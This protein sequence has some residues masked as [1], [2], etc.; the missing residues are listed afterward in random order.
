MMNNRRRGW[1]PSLFHP[2]QT[3]D[4]WLCRVKPFLSTLTSRQA[5]FIAKA[6]SDLGNG[7]MNLSQKANLQL[8]GFTPDHIQH[9]IPL[10]QREKLCSPNVI[11]EEKRN[12]L[13]SPLA[14]IDPSC[15]PDTLNYAHCLQHEIIEHDTIKF[16]TGK[17]SFVIDGGGQFPLTHH[18]ADLNLRVH[19]NQWMLQMGQ[20]KQAIPCSLDNISELIKKILQFCHQHHYNRLLHQDHTEQFIKETA[21]SQQPYMDSIHPEKLAIGLFTHGYHLGIPFGLLSSQAL[22]TLADLSDRYGDSTLRLTPDRTIILPYCSANAHPYLKSF[23]TDQDDP[24]LQII[25]C[26]GKPYC[27]QGQQPVMNDVRKLI[28]FWHKRQ[29]TLH[30]SGCAKGCASPQKNPVTL[31]A[32]PKGYNLILDGKADDK[33]LY[34]DLSL[35]EI[36]TQLITYPEIY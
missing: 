5:R 12:L 35:T 16:L 13:V 9:F 26:P 3:G 24:R 29:Q 14:G 11:E 36:T 17:F 8:R 25:L 4:G 6:A 32:T 18:H 33:S 7:F 21:Y 23:I 30:I 22:H 34:Q 2:M 20:A 28:P 19:Q 15:H 27:L 1:C 31:C 10:A